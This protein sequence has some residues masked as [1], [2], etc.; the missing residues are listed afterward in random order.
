MAEWGPAA[1][2]SGSHS[3]AAMALTEGQQDGIVLEYTLMVA[4]QRDVMDR[5][6]TVLASLEQLQPASPAPM[7]NTNGVRPR[8]TLQPALHPMCTSCTRH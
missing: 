8:R 3:Q 7:S 2:P 6:R 1:D 4:Q 5:H